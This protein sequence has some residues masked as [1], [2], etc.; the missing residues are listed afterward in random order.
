M[1]PGRLIADNYLKRKAIRFF[2]DGFSWQHG[3]DDPNR[4]GDPLI[5][6][7]M[8]CLLSYIGLTE[9]IIYIIPK[10]KSKGKRHSMTG[11]FRPLFLRREGGILHQMRLRA[12]TSG[13]ERHEAHHL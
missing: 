12:L 5:T 3:A 7:E 9:Q 8:L 11:V 6:S 10:K 4:T 2:E 1:L 13:M